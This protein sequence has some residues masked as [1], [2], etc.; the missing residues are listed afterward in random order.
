MASAYL[1]KGNAIQLLGK[2]NEAIDEYEKAIAIRKDLVENGRTELA[3][4]LASAYM[5][6]GN[7]LFQQNEFAEAV[8]MFSGAINLWET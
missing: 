1:N 6:K 3:N 2:F 5:N 7:V 4:D 8:E